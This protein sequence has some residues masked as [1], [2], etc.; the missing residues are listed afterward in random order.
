VQDSRV[1]LKYSG[2]EELVCRNC[3]A[4]YNITIV[5]RGEEDKVIEV[6]KVNESAAVDPSSKSK[7]A[8]YEPPKKENPESTK[9]RSKTVM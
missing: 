7:D 6:M 2:S 1:P 8:E 4:M 3:Y 5:G 9:K